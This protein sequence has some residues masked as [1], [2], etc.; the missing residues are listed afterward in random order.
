M[1]DDGSGAVPPLLRFDD[2]T[3]DLGRAQLLRDGHPVKLRRQSFDVLAYL[4]RSH[5]RVVSVDELVAAVWAVRPSNPDVSVT[6][7][8]KDVRRGLGD[9]ARWMVRTVSGQGYEFRAEFRPHNVEADSHSLD[10]AGGSAS[11]R[12]VPIDVAGSTPT[13]DAAAKSVI[14]RVRIGFPLPA[15]LRALNPGVPGVLVVAILLLGVIGFVAGSGRGAAPS[16]LEVMQMMAVPTLTVEPLAAPVAEQN[17]LA[18]S[19]T[20]HI[21]QQLSRSPGGFQ[22][23]VRTVANA[24][25]AAPSP[26]SRY[27]LRGRLGDAAGTRNLV[28]HLQETASGRAIWSELFPSL[29]AGTV[30]TVAARIARTAAIHIRLAESNRPMPARPEAGHYALLGRVLL[31]NGRG[32]EK[33]RQTM[34]VFDKALALDGR[35][36]YALQGYARTRVA[37]VAN[38]WCKAEQCQVFLAQAERAID[39]AI[40]VN[41]R[42]AGPHI[43]RGVLERIKGNSERA[44]ASLERALEYNPDYPLA[45]AEMG[46]TR[47][48]LGQYAEAEADITR[49]FS[50]NRD[51]D[52]SAIWYYWS[53]MAAV[54]RGSDEVAVQAFTN[55]L[56][57]NRGYKEQLPWLAIAYARL[58]EIQ[59]AKTTIAEYL[60]LHPAFSTEAWLRLHPTSKSAVASQRQRFAEILETLGVPVDAP[61]IAEPDDSR[62]SVR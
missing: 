53:G 26:A 16:S 25:S 32:A 14:D 44:L 9:D 45:H 31:E 40:D 33:N 60:Q 59:K 4:V 10:P 50:L 29:D 36:F 12:T 5:G 34:D 7:C 15:G 28:V 18:I 37:A 30:Q 19:V 20:D 58:N 38:G 47:I 13:E 3:L 42:G 62:P 8:I 43:L 35:H 11:D 23:S 6:Q 57:R 22:L 41:Q 52:V 17:D 54:H 21:T 55:A 56:Q 1:R 24:S 27:V 46:R 48:D 49:A 51:D 2:F 61:R 39:T